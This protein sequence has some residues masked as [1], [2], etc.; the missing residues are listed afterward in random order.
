MGTNWSL[1]IYKE[2]D[3][4][5]RDNSS[6]WEG[7]FEGFENCPKSVKHFG[8]M[9]EHFQ[10]K[11]KKKRMKSQHLLVLS[12]VIPEAKRILMQ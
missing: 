3:Y 10:A 2:N 1:I 4:S 12:S 8:L 9:T 5:E 7:C 6:I 11:K